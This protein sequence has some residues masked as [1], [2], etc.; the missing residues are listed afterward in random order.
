[1]LL[2]HILCRGILRRDNKKYS[3]RFTYSHKPS[4][5]LL[6]KFGFSPPAGG[7]NQTF[8]FFSSWSFI[9]SH[10]SGREV[11]SKLESSKILCQRHSFG[12][13]NMS[14][15]LL[16]RNRRFLFFRNIISFI[17]HISYFSQSPLLLIR[18]FFAPCALFFTLTRNFLHNHQD[19]R[20]FQKYY[21]AE[22]T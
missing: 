3:S 5:H 6:V 21:V 8:R 19:L 2:T 12:R 15:G 16:W 14:E 9:P 1:M 13:K 22:A 20:I 17:L 4:H 18:S 7:S 10:Q 11:S